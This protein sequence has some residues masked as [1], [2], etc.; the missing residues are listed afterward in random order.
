MA[1]MTLLCIIGELRAVVSARSYDRSWNSYKAGFV[2]LRLSPDFQSVLLFTSEIGSPDVHTLLPTPTLIARYPSLPPGLSLY[3]N[4]RRPPCSSVL[5]KDFAM[6][7]DK[8]L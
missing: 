6:G 7:K 4:R 8:Y 5:D 3:Y 2:T 1:E